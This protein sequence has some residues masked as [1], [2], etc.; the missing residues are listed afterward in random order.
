VDFKDFELSKFTYVRAQESLLFPKDAFHV[1]LGSNDLKALSFFNPLARTPVQE[2]NV[3]FSK[4][5]LF[6]LSFGSYYFR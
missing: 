2:N 1:P 6:G 3:A 5:A 4:S